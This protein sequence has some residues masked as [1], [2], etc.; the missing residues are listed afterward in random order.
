MADRNVRSTGPADAVVEEVL[1][2]GVGPGALVV[3]PGSVENSAFAFGAGPGVGLFA[4]VV[5]SI[6]ENRAVFVVVHFMHVGFVPGLNR[7]EAFE[8]LVIG[9]GVG[10]FEGAGAVG[11]E[12]CTSELRQGLGVE[13]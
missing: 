3:A 1:E 9:G 12:A 5:D 10:F 4:L 6:G 13:E 11:F 7:V 2:I 8:N